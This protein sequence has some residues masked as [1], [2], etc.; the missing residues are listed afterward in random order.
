MEKKNNNWLKENPLD[1]SWRKD[2]IETKMK[3]E[4]P[5]WK[6]NNTLGVKM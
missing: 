5:N 6:K 1:K 2:H 4:A 3:V